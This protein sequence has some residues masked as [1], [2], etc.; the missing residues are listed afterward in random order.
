MKSLLLAMALSV[1]LL[2]PMD[3]NALVGS[4]FAHRTIKTVGAV[5]AIGG[6]VITGTGLIGA[7]ATAH[8]WS[9]LGW[10]V[11]ALGGAATAGLGLIIL[12]DNTVV[13]IEFREIDSD[14]KELLV[15]KEDI[16][17]YNSEVDLLNMI[18]KTII[19]ET[20]EAENTD[21]AESR[22]L[23]YADY[24]HPSTFKVAQEVGKAF[25][26]K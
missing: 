21:D 19:A 24:I 3:A 17:I 7:M 15:S 13:D 18:R 11:I 20:D 5:G 22:W 8:T 10:M 25:L 14:Q 6:G 1:T 12:D 9:A 23:E 16:E 4:I 26:A 2:K